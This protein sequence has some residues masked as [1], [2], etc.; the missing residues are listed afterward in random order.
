MHVDDKPM[1]KTR[2]AIVQEGKLPILSDRKPLLTLPNPSPSDT[3]NAHA[4]STLQPTKT[5]RT[6]K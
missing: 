3:S 5:A 1:K 2:L 6:P 4:S